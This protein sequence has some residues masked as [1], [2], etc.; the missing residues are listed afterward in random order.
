MWQPKNK[1]FPIDQFTPKQFKIL[2]MHF[3]RKKP[4]SYITMKLKTSRAF[5]SNTIKLA[6]KY[7]PALERII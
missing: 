3:D 1:D 7:C 6:V 4:Y 2:K 5:I